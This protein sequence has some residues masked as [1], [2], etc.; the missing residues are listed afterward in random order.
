MF[1]WTKTTV[2]ILFIDANPLIFSERSGNIKTNRKIKIDC[3][4]YFKQLSA[5][6]IY[7]FIQFE[8]IAS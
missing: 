3:L 6:K 4:V 7:G 8:D 1:Y 5:I 2:P